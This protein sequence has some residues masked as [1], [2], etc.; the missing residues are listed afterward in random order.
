MT[1]GFLAGSGGMLTGKRSTSEDCEIAK[2]SEQ[3]T[4]AKFMVG[5]WNNEK[6]STPEEFKRWM[7]N[8]AEGYEDI[9]YQ[10]HGRSWF[11]LSG[12]RGDQIYYEKTIFSCSERVVNV[13]AIAY[14]EAERQRFDPIVERMEDD[15][16]GGR[17]CG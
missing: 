5:A 12:H 2:F 16:K 8:H 11:V 7:L 3:K 9:T 13:F 4:D 14:P 17:G 15:F 10:P 1:V 6:D